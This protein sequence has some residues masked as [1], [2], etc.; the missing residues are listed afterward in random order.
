M[1]SGAGSVKRKARHGPPAVVNGSQQQNA[2]F[3]AAK[4]RNQEIVSS[5]CAVTT[6]ALKLKADS[7]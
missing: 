5:E 7:E 2:A 3:G 1:L 4:S 6:S